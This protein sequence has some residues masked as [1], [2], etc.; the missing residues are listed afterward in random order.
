MKISLDKDDANDDDSNYFV[1]SCHVHSP[2]C[3]HD[4]VSTSE[5]P[6]EVVLLLFPHNSSVAE[7]GFEPVGVQNL[8]HAWTSHSFLGGSMVPWFRVGLWSQI[9]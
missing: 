6:C 8:C 7:Q 5:Q 2:R 9:Y 4:F 3:L 1:F